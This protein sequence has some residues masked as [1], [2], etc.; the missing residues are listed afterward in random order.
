MV[1][2]EL[3]AQP[4]AE[5]VLGQAAEV[6]H[7]LLEPPQRARG[8]VRPA[9]RVCPQLARRVRHEIDERLSP[10]HD[11]HGREPYA[12]CQCE[13]S[14]TGDWLQTDF[15]AWFSYHDPEAGHRRLSLA[16]LVDGELAAIHARLVD[17]GSPAKAA[18]K[19]L[20]GWF[21]GLAARS[22]GFAVLAA[23][24]W[25]ELE[26]DKLRWHL[27]PGGWADRLELGD[28]R[29][30]VPPGH[31]WQ[32]AEV[33]VS[34]R[35]RNERMVRALATAL[36][37]LVDA[38]RPL[39]PLG[40]PR[41]VGRDRRRA[42]RPARVP[43]RAA[44]DARGGRAARA[45]R[46]RRRRA[47]EGPAGTLDR[48]RRVRDPQGRLLPCLHGRRLAVHGLPAA[49]GLRSGAAG[50]GAEPVTD[51]RASD[52]ERE[53]TVERLRDAAA[54]GR[55]TFEELA[56][57]IE[58]AGAAVMRSDLA[59]LTADLPAAVA[60]RDDAPER[61]H[62]LGDVKRSGSWAVPGEN[63]F[64]SWLGHIKLDLRQARISGTE[65]HIHAWSLFGN[66]DLLV[67]EGV[68]V[69]VRANARLGQVKQENSASGARGAADRP[70]RRHGLRRHQDPPQ[71]AVGEVRRPPAQLSGACCASASTAYR[72]SPMSSPITC[73]SR[74]GRCP[75]PP[76]R[77]ARAPRR[78]R[79]AARG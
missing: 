47:L 50:P 76:A 39:G 78:R 21:G 79:R 40:A 75:S 42:R 60:I 36:E 18:T 8:V 69:D 54:E 41:A 67:P 34:E 63:H 16:E 58:A 74:S 30:L 35:E 44:R 11:R 22:L 62:A 70:H 65:I 56:D 26:P 55:L 43:V 15:A 29:A 71:A 19:Y 7:V 57:R 5:A 23:D 68:A 25:F 20:A 51:V 1:L 4:R 33:V 9:A 64:R 6:V 73:R 48:G 14:V 53:A 2:D 37:P 12:L 31:A 66:I 3:G 77:R 49:R 52:A 32:D 45:S 10:D 24:A 72:R 61:V 59:P 27:H 28:T 38:L 17:G 46:R 13:G